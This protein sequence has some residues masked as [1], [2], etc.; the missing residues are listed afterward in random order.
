MAKAER[1]PTA[2]DLLHQQHLPGTLDLSV[3]A[4]LVM[5]RKSGVLARQDPPCI[6]HK[7]PKQRRILKVDRFDREIDLRLRPGSAF[8]KAA[9]TAATTAAL[10]VGIRLAGHT[11]LT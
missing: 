4:A 6:G 1:P 10:P 3:Q 7:L 9:G 8:F 5:R 11:G 2:H